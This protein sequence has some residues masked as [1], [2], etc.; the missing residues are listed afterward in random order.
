MR[1]A[2]LAT[3]RPTPF[4][5][6]PTAAER[7]AIAQELGIVAIKKLRFAGTLAPQDRTDWALQA[8]LGATVVQH[9]VV[10]LDP[11]TTRIDEDVSLSYVAEMPE[12]DAAEVEM[13]VADT[14]EA[15]PE[16]LDLVQVM[17]EALSLA[18]PA[19]PRAEGA[20]LGDATYAPP[21]VAPMKDDDAKPFAGLAG[22][23]ESLEKKGK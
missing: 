21:G 11:V 15:L 6:V 22:L 7:Q 23:R 3:N 5:L 4:E 13:P 1:L 17:I 16:S 19:Y 12:I 9:C 8:K 10:T 14:V 20:D 18:L 2:E